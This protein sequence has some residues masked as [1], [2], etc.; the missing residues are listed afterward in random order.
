MEG[1]SCVCSSKLQALTFAGVN[2]SL[3][4]IVLMWN[5]CS[6][7][8][9]YKPKWQLTQTHSFLPPFQRS[10]LPGLLARKPVLLSHRQFH[11]F[12]QRKLTRTALS[13]TQNH[14]YV[15]ITEGGECVRV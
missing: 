2:I 11:Q 12:F 13:I 10:L 6:G 8:I 5:F 15:L 14:T 9:V 3:C 4:Y 7:F 1:G